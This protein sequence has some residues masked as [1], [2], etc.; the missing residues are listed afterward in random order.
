ML[1]LSIGIF[2]EILVTVAFPIA[3]GFWLNKKKGISW[4][5]I[6]YGAIAYFIMQTLT[7]VVFI[8]FTMLVE[9][10]ALPLQDPALRITQVGLSILLGAIF[11]A[12]VRWIGMNKMKEDLKDLPSAWA[13]GL[14]YGG[15]ETIQLVGLPLVSTFWTMLTNIN[16]DPATTSLSPDIISQLEELWQVPFY[17]PLAGAM[18]RIGAMVM[19]LLVTVL[20]LQIFKQNKKWFLAAAIGIEVLVNGLVAGLSEVG[21]ETGWVILVAVILMAGNLY[22]LKYLKAFDLK[23]EPSEELPVI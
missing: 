8:G 14:G 6:G 16:L 15:V 17:I 13:I 2:I 9:N 22:L 18:E 10:G 12:L 3:A 5:K 23:A 7:T 20:I 11:G 4:R 19:H 1:P 21:F